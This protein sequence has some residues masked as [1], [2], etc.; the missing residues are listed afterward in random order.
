[1]QHF[2]SFFLN[3]K[4]NVL[5]KR[6]LLLLNAALAIAILHLISQ[7]HLPSFVIMLPI[8]LKDS[9]FSSCF[10]VYHTRILDRYNSIILVTIF[11]KNT[12]DYSILK[13]T[14][15]ILHNTLRSFFL[16]QQLNCQ[17]ALLTFGQKFI[18]RTYKTKG[19]ELT[20]LGV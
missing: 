16:S 11:K 2:T 3:S 6:V 7:V 20:K 17:T 13:V 14:S 8:Y 19:S 4:S 15:H 5:V 10:L 9:T 18:A 1:M 12:E